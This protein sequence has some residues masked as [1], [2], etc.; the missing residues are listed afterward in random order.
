[1]TEVKDLAGPQSAGLWQL[2]VMATQELPWPGGGGGL[3]PTAQAA[4]RQRPYAAK[5]RRGE[6]RCRTGGIALSEASG[7]D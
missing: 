4:G 2:G 6:R 1:M 3:Q 7:Q 5:L